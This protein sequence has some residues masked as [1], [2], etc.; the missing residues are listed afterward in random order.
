MCFRVLGGADLSG[1]QV[2]ISPRCC[3]VAPVLCTG[4]P[5]A[6]GLVNANATA[7]QPMEGLPGLSIC[8]SAVIGMAWCTAEWQQA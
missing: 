7:P 4:L 6:V 3:T 8:F 5:G 1:A 2:R